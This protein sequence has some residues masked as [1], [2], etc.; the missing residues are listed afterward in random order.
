MAAHDP[1]DMFR[2]WLQQLGSTSGFHPDVWAVPGEL[3]QCQSRRARNLSAR[4]NWRPHPADQNT[5]ICT[6]PF[7]AAI[8]PETARMALASVC[9]SVDRLL[10]LN[11]R[12]LMCAYMTM[13]W[14]IPRCK[15]SEKVILD[16][17]RGTHELLACL[18]L[19]YFGM[20]LT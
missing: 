13:H 20:G 6:L 16:Q 1:F 8:T 12:Q 11:E 14:V 2:E 3:F 10:G 18:I 4:W 17:A 19:L 15:R 5:T 9:H 7:S